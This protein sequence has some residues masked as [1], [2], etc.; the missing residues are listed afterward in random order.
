VPPPQGPHLV[1]V[2]L[3]Q[4]LPGTVPAAGSVEQQTQGVQHPR[5]ALRGLPV[6]AYLLQVALPQA[7][8]RLQDGVHQGALLLGRTAVGESVK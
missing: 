7:P 5:H 4:E 6:A 3:S 1:E 2:G 8:Q